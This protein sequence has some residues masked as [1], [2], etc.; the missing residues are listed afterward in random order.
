MSGSAEF[1][2]LTS[3]ISNAYASAL[4]ARA[5]DR[6]IETL[7]AR[8]PEAASGGAFATAALFR[9]DAPTILDH[10]DLAEE[11]FGPATVIV[12]HKSREDA[13][14]IARSIEGQLTATV[15]GTEEDLAENA[16]LIRVLETRV[17]R[18]V[19]NG[20]PTG[21]EVCD[22]MVHGGP[23]PATS[24]GRSTSVGSRAINRFSRLVSYQGFPGVSLPD[25]LKDSNPLGIW[26]M[27]D[28]KMTREGF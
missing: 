23:F 14:N 11:V 16:E 17:G 8:Q 1:T 3:G 13:I 9:T 18:I 22:A 28:G 6:R 7:A 27:T 21:V 4:A 25:E 2:M 24:D 5:A 10:P 12:T 26:R 15:H 19:F 20:F